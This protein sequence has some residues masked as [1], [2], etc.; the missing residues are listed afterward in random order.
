M[1]FTYEE[2]HDYS[3][4]INTT[5][6]HAIL[7][8]VVFSEHMEIFTSRYAG[9]EPPTP[10]YNWESYNY[11]L[12]GATSSLNFVRSILNPEM[13]LKIPPSPFRQAYQKRIRDYTDEDRSRA[14]RSHAS[15]IIRYNVI[16][17]TYATGGFA[18]ET[19]TLPELYETLRILLPEE[20]LST[21]IPLSTYEDENEE[22]AHNYREFAK[23][24][25]RD[26]AKLRKVAMR[27]KKRTGASADPTVPHPHK[28]QV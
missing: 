23:V 17:A 2:F 28:P 25:E 13:P 5:I 10:T 16:A 7:E 12:S 20:D 24:L 4:Y 18:R 1:P 14:N 22:T 27:T 6:T 19:K 11:H 26:A 8:G 9:D 15:I 3:L 21:E